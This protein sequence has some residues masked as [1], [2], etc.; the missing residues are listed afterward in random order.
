MSDAA[1]RGY[2][3]YVDDIL[4]RSRTFEA[5]L[6]EIRHVLSQQSKAGA[7]LSLTKGQWCRT[8]V[9]YVGLLVGANGIEPQTGRVQAI[10]DIKAPTVLTELRSFLGICNYSRQFIEDYAEIA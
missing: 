2:L 8:K 5:H 3:I 7:T 6:V 10:Q 9:E 4:V 1:A